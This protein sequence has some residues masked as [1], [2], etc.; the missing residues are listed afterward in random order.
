MRN[1]VIVGDSQTGKSSFLRYLKGQEFTE[2][3]MATPGKDMATIKHKN[4]YL[5]V[6]DM[7]GVERF[8][9]I[10]SHYYAHACGALVF[11][12][13]ESELNTWVDKLELENED[14]PIVVVH[15]KK[16][17]GTQQPEDCKY[18]YIEIS[19][20]T[21]EN[22]NNVL[23]LLKIKEVKTLPRETWR[24]YFQQLSYCSLQ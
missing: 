9:N 5:I 6:H 19:C 3:Y 2:S 11:I 23:S 10:C 22:V 14:I 20:K 4:K 8:K 21:G 1:I 7:T 12:T 15:N 24:T 13:N 16:D 18:P 17:V